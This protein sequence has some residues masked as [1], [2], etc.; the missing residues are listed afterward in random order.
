MYLVMYQRIGII[1]TT[2]G[3]KVKSFVKLN[4]TSS[5]GPSLERRTS[6]LPSQ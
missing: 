6:T 5:L 4:A 1:K 3:L 2:K